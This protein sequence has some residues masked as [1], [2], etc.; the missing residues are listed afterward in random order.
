MRSIKERFRRG[1]T[2]VPNFVD[3]KLH[4]II[5]KE[6]LHNEYGI[7]RILETDLWTFVAKYKVLLGLYEE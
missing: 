6:K 3:D 2:V 1:F 7:P 5:I 4:N